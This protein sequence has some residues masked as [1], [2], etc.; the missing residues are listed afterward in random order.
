MLYAVRL[1]ASSPKTR[2]PSPCPHSEL[3]CHIGNSGVHPLATSQ[4][5]RSRRHDF[6]GEKNG[7]Y[8]SRQGGSLSDCL[9]AGHRPTRFLPSLE[10]LGGSRLLQDNQRLPGAKTACAGNIRFR[11]FCNRNAARGIHLTWKSQHV[12]QS[13]PATGMLA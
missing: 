12:R 8:S 1:K 13:L 2:G 4:L 6:R 7:F 11:H 9:S 10:F 5:P 3:R